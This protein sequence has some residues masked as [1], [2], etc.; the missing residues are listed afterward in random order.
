MGRMWPRAVLQWVVMPAPRY[1][2]FQAS[3]PCDGCEV[4]TLCLSAAQQQQQQPLSGAV[5]PTS[6]SHH[7]QL[8]PI[9]GSSLVGPTAH[10]NSSW[11]LSHTLY[12]PRVARI[13]AKLPTTTWSGS[14]NQPENFPFHCASRDPTCRACNAACDAALRRWRS[15]PRTCRS[16]AASADGLGCWLGGMP[17][18]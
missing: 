7:M 10:P 17:A 3:A 5:P 13:P 18:V 4:L 16:I 15:C 9:E 8:S 12:E 14:C 11:P 2:S 1:H 6:S